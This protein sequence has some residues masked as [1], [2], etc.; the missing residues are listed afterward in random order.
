[1]VY[2][3]VGP[4]DCRPMPRRHDNLKQKP[5]PR[6][7]RIIGENGLNPFIQHFQRDRVNAPGRQCGSRGCIENNGACNFTRFG[8]AWMRFVKRFGGRNPMGHLPNV[9]LGSTVKPNYGPQQF[10]FILQQPIQNAFTVCLV[11]IQSIRIGL[12]PFG[13]GRPIEKLSV[14]QRIRRPHGDGG[15]ENARGRF[16][17]GAIRLVIQ[18]DQLRISG[19]VQAQAE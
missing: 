10:S 8:N 6:F 16:T 13:R 1:M 5:G 17:M 7:V 15:G 9:E 3:E 19:F 12:E 14:D 4:Y 2:P 18:A 11:P